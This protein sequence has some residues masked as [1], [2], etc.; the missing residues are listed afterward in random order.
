M[1]HRGTTVRQYGG[2]LLPAP[3]DESLSLIHGNRVT[4]FAKYRESGGRE[5]E[6]GLVMSRSTPHPEIYEEGEEWGW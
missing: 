3:G 6:A 2:R 1:S 5:E 4:D